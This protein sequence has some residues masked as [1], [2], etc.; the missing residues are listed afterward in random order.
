MMLWFEDRYGQWRALCQCANKIDVG[1][2]IKRFL[3]KHNFKSYYTRTWD[4]DGF[5]HY[6]VGSHV[7]FFH[8]EISSN[9]KFPKGVFDVKFDALWEEAR[10]MAEQHAREEGDVN[11]DE[12]YEILERWQEQN[13][14]YLCEREGLD[15]HLSKYM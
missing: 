15:Y 3:D 4:E 5:R 6:D 13:F 9:P 11:I 2:A 7:E 12:D 14:I 1:I 8:W 10:E